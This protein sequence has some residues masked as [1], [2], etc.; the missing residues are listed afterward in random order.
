M[1]S[2]YLIAAVLL[3]F[4]STNAQNNVPVRDTMVDKFMD[5]A[6]EMDTSELT[7]YGEFRE[8]IKSYTGANKSTCS[9]VMGVKKYFAD[10]DFIFDQLLLYQKLDKT[11]KRENEM[12]LLWVTGRTHERIAINKAAEIFNC[13]TPDEVK[14][15]T[16]TQ[17]KNTLQNL[18]NLSGY[19][20]AT[21]KYQTLTT[22]STTL[23]ICETAS[24]LKRESDK[25]EPYLEKLVI[26]YVVEPTIDKNANPDRTVLFT[27]TRITELAEKFLN[28]RTKQFL[29]MKDKLK[30]VLA[31]Y[32]CN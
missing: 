17:I 14:E 19:I 32:N 3:L 1:K 30:T 15:D 10:N 9:Y 13:M 7:A 5:K 8:A 11:S 24:A 29:P 27:D 4:T 22:T 25:I 16:R 18:T 28:F 12:I 31:K 6:V 2:I 26:L 23:E 20:E 21:K